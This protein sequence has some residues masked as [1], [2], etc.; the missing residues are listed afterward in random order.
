MATIVVAMKEKTR[1]F[2]FFIIL[3]SYF[4]NNRA[5]AVFRPKA[6][7]RVLIFCKTMP[8]ENVSGVQI[9][10]DGVQIGNFG[11]QTGNY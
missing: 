7:H 8:T 10:N 5:L 1:I 6:R 3:L 11:A 4:V 2:D 9:G